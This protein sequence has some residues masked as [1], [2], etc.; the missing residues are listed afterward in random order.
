M[1]WYSWLQVEDDDFSILQ[2]QNAA[3]TPPLPPALVSA[4]GCRIWVFIKWETSCTMPRVAQVAVYYTS[5]PHKHTHTHTVDVTLPRLFHHFL[6]WRLLMHIRR[7]KLSLTTSNSPSYDA[8]TGCNLHFNLFPLISDK[9]PGCAYEFG[10]S[11]RCQARSFP[12]SVNSRS[13]RLLR[14]QQ[15]ITKQFQISTCRNS[16]W[17]RWSTSEF[18]SALF[19]SPGNAH[20][21]RQSSA[22]YL[23][24]S[25]F[26]TNLPCGCV[27]SPNYPRHIS[28]ISP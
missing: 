20:G 17:F 6:W 11:G 4:P 3:V 5:I 24:V 15:R 22:S 21:G 9:F 16:P 26:L 8:V 2:Q 25:S 12:R 27:V 7:W 14:K 28:H 13:R 19:V 18:S 23:S 10:W 1:V